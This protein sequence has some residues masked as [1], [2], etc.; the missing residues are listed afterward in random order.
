MKNI[1]QVKKG[2]ILKITC[3]IDCACRLRSMGMCEG[4]YAEITNDCNPVIIK[5]GGTSIAIC[6][7]LAD[8][9]IIDEVN[10]E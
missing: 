6:K 1:N 10:N 2:H 8:H 5:C 7:S 4:D 9:I 3:P